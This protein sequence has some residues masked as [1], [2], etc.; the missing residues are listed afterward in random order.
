VSLSKCFTAYTF[1]HNALIAVP[2]KYPPS[3]W[4]AGNNFP[5]SIAAVG[6][7]HPNN[8]VNGDYRLLPTSP[9]KNAGTDGKDLGADI[10]AIRHATAGAY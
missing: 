10:N 8:G 3:Q 7:V 1:N 5:A 2:S 4:P 9:Y 6:F